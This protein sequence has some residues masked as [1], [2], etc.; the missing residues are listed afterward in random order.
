LIGPSDW[1]P[2][3]M[4]KEEFARR[5]EA[6]WRDHPSA[7][8]AVVYGN[9]A[10]HAELAYLTNLVPKLEAS[11]ALLARTG[12]HKLLL[13]G[14]PN[15]LGAARPLTFIGDLAPLRG[16]QAV[17]QAA[18]GDNPAGE[19]LL[20]GMGSMPSAF[21]Q[22]LV[23][24]LGGAPAPDATPALWTQMR[25]KSS[26]E[27]AAGREACAVLTAT[28]KAIAEAHRGGASV[29]AAVLAGERAANAHGAQD[30]R[31][32]FSRNG[33]RTLQPFVALTDERVDP[34]QVYVAVRRF[35]YWAEG[36]ASL[37]AHDNPAGNKARDVLR[38]TRSAIKAGA[39]TQDVGSLIISALRPDRPHPVTEAAFASAVGLALH[40]SPHTDVGATF[41]SGEIYSL[42]IGLTDDADRHAIV[43]AM[44][45]VHDRGNDVL[46][47]VA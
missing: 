12:E 7:T 33:G 25:R 32:L 19:V 22:A 2:E 9:P 36:F 31:T 35:N 17:G 28:M 44:I 30:V 45:A 15:M 47:N 26:H 23:V 42:K 43:S 38:L 8:R 14:G 24:A 41:E 4:P 1:Q 11:V 29:T 6:L 20:I 21:R 3:R 34:L 10:H 46:W 13:G 18:I 5:I 16:G 39:P 37:S 40:A 27:L